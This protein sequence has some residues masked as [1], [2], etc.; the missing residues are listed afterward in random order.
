M[1]LQAI[2]RTRL[3]PTPSGFL[4]LGNAFSFITTALVAKEYHAGILLRIDDLDKERVRQEY[5]EDIFGTLNFLGIEW[6][7]GPKS[8]TEYR[9]FSQFTRLEHYDKA[10]NKLVQLDAVY[11][12]QCSRT[13]YAYPCSCKGSRIDLN[14]K[15]ACWRLHTDAPKQLALNNLDGT[16]EQFLLP[17]SQTDFIVRKKDGLPSYQL[18]SLVDDG[19]FNI[20]LIVRGKDLFD[21]TLAQLY[22][23]TVLGEEVFLQARFLHH[24]LLLNNDGTKL[25]KSAGDTSIQY[26]R[27]HGM[28]RDDI[29]RMLN[30]AM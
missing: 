27:K 5:V 11:A 10:L 2:N 19:F 3:A 16:Q 14:E 29:Y 25:S 26:L 20:N 28:S 12:C 1:N 18:A 30:I 4:H 21:S 13:G 8:T 17:V 22:L 7:E 6:Q 9:T 23:A 15:D 24:E